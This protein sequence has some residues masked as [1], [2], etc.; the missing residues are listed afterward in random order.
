MTTKR[1][2]KVL[3]ASAL[4]GGLAGCEGSVMGG[5]SVP[6]AG[7]GPRID[8]AVVRVVREHGDLGLDLDPSDTPDDG[9]T[10]LPDDSAPLD[11][12]WRA[13]LGERDLDYGAAL[14]TASLRLRGTLP[15]LV[16]I[17]F[18]A[19]SSD[20]RRAYES[21]LDQMLRDPRFAG[22][23]FDF[24]R[25]TFRMGGDDELNGAPAFAARLVF[26]SDDFTRLF[27]ATSGAC[28]SFDRGAGTF[29]AGDCDNGVPEH[30]GV[31]THPGVMRH[32][33][34]NLAFR[35]V[36]WVQ[37]VFAC[38]PFPA[39]VTREV[40]VGGAAPYTA[41]WP[42]ESI[43]GADT[44]G[45]VDF[46]DTS[47]VI[48]ANCHATMNHLAPLFARFDANGAWQDD[49]Q[50]VLPLDGAPAAARTDWLVEGEGTAWRFGV[51]V[52]DLPA[53]GRAMAADPEVER[54]T[55]ARTWNWAMGHGDVIGN[56][57]VVP[58]DVLAAA[59]ATYRSEG[60]DLRAALRTIFT[61]DDFLRF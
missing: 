8:P 61:S 6:A 40:D 60:H 35:R 33:Y 53:L 26:E 42:F 27:T 59:L 48:C 37:E 43:A 58:A 24:F 19:E 20:P 15:T 41:P 55:V 50:V 34:S 57:D 7:E 54:C 23:L 13:R 29:T 22:Q 38:E 10:D 39:E 18:L 51:P 3:L 31:L 14:R 5:S 32:F 28:T 11:A 21:L 17:R 52:A 47:A 25:D 30:A 4:V 49:I 45:R 2:A 16:E 1:I 44:G 36:R 9:Y 56:A 46:H 12:T